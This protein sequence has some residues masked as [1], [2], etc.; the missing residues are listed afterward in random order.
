M[1]SSTVAIPRNGRNGHV[2]AAA[3]APLTA[4]GLAWLGEA[5]DRLAGLRAEKRRLETAERELTRAVLAH[6]TEHGLPAFRAAQ[7]VAVVT[8]RAELVPDPEL[9][10]T[11][12]GLPAATP[13]L[14]VLVE[15]ARELLGEND[16]AAISETTRVLTLRVDRIHGPA[17]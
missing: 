15:K 2:P 10:V 11:A 9:F 4:T 1:S 14:R 12:V 8:P 13:A 6:M 17:A 16:L 5:I 7:T 3:P